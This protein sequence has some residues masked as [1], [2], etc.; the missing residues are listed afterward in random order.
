MTSPGPAGMG[1]PSYS[2]SCPHYMFG[3]LWTTLQVT[4]LEEYLGITTGAEYDSLTYNFLTLEAFYTI[5]VDPALMTG[6]FSC[7][8]KL[9]GVTESELGV[10]KNF[11]K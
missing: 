9:P 11:L 1:R 4:A 5:S 10:H 7:P 2:D 3:L 8:C 6:K